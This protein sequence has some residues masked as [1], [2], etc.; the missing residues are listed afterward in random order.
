MAK[1]DPGLRFLAD[2]KK[3][4]LRA[5][6]DEAAFT[7]EAATGQ[8]ATATVLLQFQGD[9]SAIEAAGFK[10][11]SFA[12][13]VATGEIE[14]AQLGALEGLDSV[15]RMEV[16][17][18]LQRELDLAIPESRVDSVH[19]GPPGHR[20]AGVVVGI[21][22]S[23]IDY[24]HEA[25]RRSDGTS[26]ILAIWD[27]GLAPQAGESNPANFS[28]G[29]EYQKS[30]IDTALTSPNP[31]TVVRHQ[32]LQIPNDGFHGTHVAG[33]SAG[34]GSVAGQSRPAF[35]FVG[36]APEADIVVVANTRGRAAG[37]RGLGDSADTLDAIR[38]IFD[39]A[40]SLGRPAVVNQSQGDNIGPHDGT[41]LL[42]RGIDNLLGGPGRAMVKSAGNEGVQNRHASSTLT[43][44]VPQSV[45]FAVPANQGTPVTIDLWYGGPDRFDISITPPN[46]VAGAAVSPGSSTTVALAN[47]NQAF[48]DSDLNDPGN[49]DNRIFVV[50]SRGGNATVQAGTWSITIQGTTVTLGQWDAWIQRDARGQFL[51]PFQNP[52]RTVSV[53][54]T[55]RE[56]ITAGSYVTRGAGVGSISSF[57]S[58]G[59]TRDGRQAPT[60]AA[61]GQV[62][63]A[64]QPASTGDTYG[65]MQGT[66]MAAPVV[67]GTVALLLQ[68]NP[69]LTQTQVR[70]CLTSTARPDAFTGTTP[71]NAWG[72][73]KL[74]ANA[75]FGCV[76]GPAVSTIAP[77]GPVTVSPPC[78]PVTAG[79]P[80]PPQTVGPPCP[81][82]TFAPPCPPLTVGPPCPPPRTFGP[83]CPPRTFAPPCPPPTFAPPCPPPTFGPPCPPPRTFGPPCPPPT[84]RPPC[85]PGPPLPPVGPSAG[86]ASDTPTSG[87]WAPV[88][89]GGYGADW[90]L[91]GYDWGL[92]ATGE[93]WPDPY[94]AWP[95]SEW[96]RTQAATTGGGQA[97]STQAAEAGGPAADEAGSGVT[98]YW[99]G[100]PGY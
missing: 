55:A 12:G 72:A 71:N 67:T 47:G 78:P 62:L 80:C 77:P 60:V 75:A 63:M 26:R 61:P 16:S 64:P 25:F 19:T 7:F 53:P 87:G 5:L 79:P 93:W 92:P 31:L 9:L 24:T 98:A 54:G 40:A 59:P 29:V 35:T 8:P 56:V 41:S 68:K 73:G 14:L 38:Y 94:Q 57:S 51:P 22:D 32:D 45:S 82:F 91:Y 27:Q 34:D 20:G 21:I 18:V 70:D 88:D 89:P 6:A 48:V 65:L 37:E 39:L 97:A 96:S 49:G 15:V 74:D 17:R 58:L 1:T 43:A 90:Y 2:Q 66:S 85:P 99:H 3:T 81:P 100:N 52:A 33:I 28:Y 23:G 13:D 44:G 36:V 10:T 30:A 4:A 50:L 95:G 11:R 83:P 46:G 84:F 76:P 42:E 86:T 69:S